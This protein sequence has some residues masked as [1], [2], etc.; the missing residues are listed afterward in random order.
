MTDD[1][2]GSIVEVEELL[3]RYA[4]RQAEEARAVAHNNI[5]EFLHVALANGPVAVKDLEEKARAAGLLRPDQPISQ[6]KPF[7]T[8][9]DKIG[10]Q[11]LQKERRWFWTMADQPKQA[12]SDISRAAD[13][14]PDA[15]QPAA[16]ATGSGGP[17]AAESPVGSVAAPIGPD[18]ASMTRNQF[19]RWSIEN[20][21]TLAIEA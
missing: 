4:I 21:R 8:I 16:V 14:H 1:N 15:P 7:R 6:C 18:F 12:A 2:N 17:A 5:R 20:R 19:I 11:R 3:H 13:A 10:V 9:A